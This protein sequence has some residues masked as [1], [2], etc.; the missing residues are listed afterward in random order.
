MAR[1]INIITLLS[2]QQQHLAVS[3]FEFLQLSKAPLQNGRGKGAGGGTKHGKEGDRGGGV[4]P[5]VMEVTDHEN[6]KNNQVVVHV[7]NENHFGSGRVE[8]KQEVDAASVSTS[9]SGGTKHHD[10]EDYD[11][12][13]DVEE[14]FD[15][16]TT[17]LEEFRSYMI[18]EQHSDAVG[19]ATDELQGAHCEDGSAECATAL[20][21]AERELVVA[22]A[23]WEIYSAD[24]GEG[25]LAFKQEVAEKMKEAQL[26]YNALSNQDKKK[27]E[28]NQAHYNKL[29]ALWVGLLNTYGNHT[30]TAMEHK[31]GAC[32][33]L[34]VSAE[35]PSY[36]TRLK[37]SFEGYFTDL[38]KLPSGPN[39]GS[40]C[41]RKN[42]EEDAGNQFV[43]WFAECAADKTT[44]KQW[45]EVADTLIEHAGNS[46][47]H[48]MNNVQE[49][50]PEARGRLQQAM[51]NAKNTHKDAP[52]KGP[53][54]LLDLVLW[55]KFFTR[56]CAET[57]NDFHGRMKQ[58]HEEQ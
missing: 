12:L 52:M 29:G 9:S 21:E 50:G 30:R 57:R 17:F 42:P 4:L 45:E 18:H 28:T 49:I 44:Q 15:E 1:S 39:G 2:H 16:E 38:E 55:K 41:P 37:K 8:E 47:K 53:L 35:I 22:A 34:A 13:E 46:A 31:Y 54:Q 56:K 6:G 11:T 26:T 51:N 24:G 3:G 58:R 5:N 40:M 7:E 27:S 25:G 33:P 10:V 32:L 14:D 36:F 48:D 23:V 20:A 43:Q 19:G